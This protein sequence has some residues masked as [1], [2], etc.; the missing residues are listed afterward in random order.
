MGE[1]EGETARQERGHMEAGSVGQ[2]EGK[3]DT[4]PELP[5]GLQWLSL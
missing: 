2:G 1:T 5:E 3:G 4:Q